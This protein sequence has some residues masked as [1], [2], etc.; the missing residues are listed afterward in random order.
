MGYSS[1]E[2]G[3]TIERFHPTSSISGIASNYTTEANLLTF[4]RHIGCQ[5]KHSVVG[6]VLV[7]IAQGRIVEADTI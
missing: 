6:G 7:E 4:E 3:N 5:L 1:H 2:R